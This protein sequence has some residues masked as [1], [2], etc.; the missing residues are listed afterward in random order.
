MAV[1]FERVCEQRCQCESDAGEQASGAAERGIVLAVALL[2]VTP[3][4]NLPEVIYHDSGSM[5]DLAQIKSRALGVY[6]NCSAPR[7]AADCHVSRQSLS[8]RMFAHA[9]AIGRIALCG[10]ARLIQ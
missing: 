9:V 7:V 5:I 10:A 6:D 4:K 2:C 1:Q 8:M 3:T